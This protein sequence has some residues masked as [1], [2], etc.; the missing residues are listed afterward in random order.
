M[1]EKIKLSNRDYRII[2][3]LHQIE[4][5]NSMILLHSAEGG[6]SFMKQQYEEMKTKLLLKLKEEF[7]ELKIPI[8]NTSYAIGA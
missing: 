6:I 4:K 2:D 1:K 8:G 7:D 3:I 5:I